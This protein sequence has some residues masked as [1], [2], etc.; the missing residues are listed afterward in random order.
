MIA[1]YKSFEVTVNQF[2]K[3]R[4]VTCFSEQNDNLLMWGH[5]GGRYKGICLEFS[6]KF[7]PFL[8]IQKVN[9]AK[10]L[11]AFDLSPLLLEKIDVPI[12]LFCT[13]SED[14]AYE[15]EWRIIHAKVGTEYRYPTEMSTRVYFGPDIDEKSLEN[16]YLMIRRQ[17]EFVKFY[18]GQLSKTEYKVLFT[19]YN[20][21][22]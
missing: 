3:E 16:V 8:K 22:E 4:G 7:E 14:W 10:S 1:G 17:N 19:P 11:P 18:R 13:K 6:T 2:L 21:T 12:E 9:Y 5:Y 20:K 15:K